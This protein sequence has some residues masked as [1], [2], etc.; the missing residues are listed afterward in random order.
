MR[1]LLLHRLQEDNMDYFSRRIIGFLFLLV[2]NLF[3]ITCTASTVSTGDANQQPAVNQ[4][5]EDQALKDIQTASLSTGSGLTPQNALVLPSTQAVDSDNDPFEKINRVIFRFNDFLDTVIMKPIATLYVK[6]MP[7]PLNKGIHNIYNNINNIPTIANDIL[8]MNFYQATNDSW[9]LV[10]N[11]TI[12]VGGLF[13]FAAVIHLPAYTNDF[14]LTLARLGYAQSHYL[15][16]PFFGP[17]TIRDTMGIPVDYY[18][19]S[20]YPYI[21]STSLQYGIWGL[22]LVDKRVQLL[23]YQ[24]VMDE[25]ALDKYVFIRNAY[26]QRRAYQIKDL[27]HRRYS[28]VVM[29]CETALETPAPPLATKTS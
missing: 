9:R 23:Q 14:G 2:L 26:L 28:D 22:G 7:K 4:T 19:F 25:A 15:V 13:D 17:S 27:G 11:S 29:N 12:G 21:H 3:P 24:A 5:D 10:V 1:V 16:L 20:I 6:I 8:Q 18:A